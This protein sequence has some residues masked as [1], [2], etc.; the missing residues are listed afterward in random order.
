M[1]HTLILLL[2]LVLSVTLFAIPTGSNYKS[3]KGISRRTG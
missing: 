3:V 2:V 1:K